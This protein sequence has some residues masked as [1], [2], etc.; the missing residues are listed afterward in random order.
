MDQFA[1]WDRF[2]EILEESRTYERA[3]KRYQKERR[4]MAAA[5]DSKELRKLERDL[6]RDAADG[7]GSAD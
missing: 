4:A 7:N 3:I 5:D 6:K 2:V 1:E